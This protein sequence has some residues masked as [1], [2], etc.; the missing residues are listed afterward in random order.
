MKRDYSDTDGR[1]EILSPLGLLSEQKRKILNVS[2]QNHTFNTTSNKTYNKSYLDCKFLIP[3]ERRHKVSQKSFH[4]SLLEN[5]CSV[6][7][8]FISGDV[9]HFE[10]SNMPPCRSMI[11]KYEYISK[12]VSNCQ[13]TLGDCECDG[14]IF[15][16]PDCRRAYHCRA[17]LSTG[18]CL[19]E[20]GE[21][22]IIIPDPRSGIT[23]FS[24]ASLSPC[25]YL[26]M[27][28]TGTVCPKNKRME[29]SS[30]VQEAGTIVMIL[31]NWITFNE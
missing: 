8:H 4:L 11:R 30:S 25:V 31:F 1:T 18:G 26:E 3:C 13:N 28:T 27:G 16:S 14:Q 5:E 19:A 12:V 20:C 23:V 15:A 29:N 24:V 10:G 21:G 2:W 22:D 7:T 9:W 17:D 6:Q